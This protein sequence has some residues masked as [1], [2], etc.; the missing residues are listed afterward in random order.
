MK[1]IVVQKWAIL[2]I[3]ERFTTQKETNWCVW[4]KS[5]NV[6]HFSVPIFISHSLLQ[7][8]KLIN[9]NDAMIRFRI[10]L[11]LYWITH[12]VSNLM[13]VDSSTSS[14]LPERITYKLIPSRS[15]NNFETRVLSE[16]SVGRYRF[17]TRQQINI[18]ISRRI[19]GRN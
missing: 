12:P 3:N 14:W 1:G 15:S 2:S 16:F 8:D 18:F 4:I 17:S 9:S 7:F 13:T 19:L 10:P 11:F 6:V 5:P